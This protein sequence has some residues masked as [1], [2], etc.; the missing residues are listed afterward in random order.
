MMVAAVELTI[1]MSLAATTASE[2]KMN[3]DAQR[4]MDDLFPPLSAEPAARNHVF[5]E[6]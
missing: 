1:P 5:P 3:A 6:G 2:S 4:N